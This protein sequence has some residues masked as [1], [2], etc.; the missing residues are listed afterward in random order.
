[1]SL[2]TRAFLSVCARKRM[3]TGYRFLFYKFKP[4][5]YFWGLLVILRNTAF[6]VTPSLWPERPQI[7]VMLY[8]LL[9]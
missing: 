6:A 9:S 8:W 2:V 5:A 4:E 1:M 3:M 7:Q